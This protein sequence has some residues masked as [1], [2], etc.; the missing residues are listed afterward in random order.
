MGAPYSE[1]GY[2]IAITRKENHEVHKNR[3]CHWREKKNFVVIIVV[4]VVV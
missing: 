3:W 4:V 2:T 1:V